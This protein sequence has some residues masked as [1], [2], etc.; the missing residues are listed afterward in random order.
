MQTMHGLFNIHYYTGRITTGSKLLSFA[1]GSPPSLV[2]FGSENQ[3]YHHRFDK[4]TG[5]DRF[6]N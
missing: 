1:S 5:V 4:Q 2:K 3:V 6:I